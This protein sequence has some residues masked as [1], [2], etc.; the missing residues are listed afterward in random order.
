LI[1]HNNVAARQMMHKLLNLAV[2]CGTMCVLLALWPASSTLYFTAVYAG[3][4]LCALLALVC[5]ER[6]L[7][8]VAGVALLMGLTGVFISWPSRPPSGTYAQHPPQAGAT[9]WIQWSSSVSGNDH[10]YALTPYATNWDAAERLAVT[11]GGTLASITSAQEQNF[12]NDTFLTGP[13]EHQPL[14]IGLVRATATGKPISSLAD[15]F[16]LAMSDLGFNVRVHRNTQFEWVT[17]EDFS[18]ANWKPGEPNNTPPGE[19]WVAINWEYSDTPP[20]GIKGDWNDTPLNGTLGF[21]GN[22]D[23]PYFGLIELGQPPGPIVTPARWGIISLVVLALAAG[24]TFV[25]SKMRSRPL[26]QQ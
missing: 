19:S 3:L 15:R 14:W 25:S 26:A 7:R 21:G 2:M 8:W 11:L 12:I 5:V 9:N 4:S 1:F 22:S 23:G 13:F 20:R 18:Y 16:R 6:P 17:G 10:Y 24:L